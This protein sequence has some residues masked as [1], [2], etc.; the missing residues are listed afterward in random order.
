VNFAE[1]EKLFSRLTTAHRWRFFDI[2]PKNLFTS[3]VASGNKLSKL[4]IITNVKCYSCLFHDFSP[5]SDHEIWFIK[6]WRLRPQ[7]VYAHALNAYLQRI[8]LRHDRQFVTPALI[9]FLF[10]HIEYH[11]KNVSFIF[12]WY[13]WNNELFSYE[14]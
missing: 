3:G 14:S 13:I 12:N 6:K 11:S 8:A 9:C 5:L 10:D 1:I 4:P 2:S 7:I